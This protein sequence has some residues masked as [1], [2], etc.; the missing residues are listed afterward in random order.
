MVFIEENSRRA[1]AADLRKNPL[2][3]YMWFERDVEN[4]F[5]KM[6]NDFWKDLAKTF[7]KTTFPDVKD[8]GGDRGAFVFEWVC[9]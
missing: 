5:W 8:R 1:T 2:V 9:T 4:D 6:K 3:H 7:S